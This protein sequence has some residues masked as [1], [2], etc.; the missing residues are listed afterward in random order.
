M[1]EHVLEHLSAYLD[2]ELGAAEQ[3]RFRAH[4]AQ[5]ASCAQRLSELAAVDRSLRELPS[6]APARYFDELPARLRGRL[7][8]AAPP[9]RLRRLPVWTLAVAATLVVGVLAPLTLLNRSAQL[10]APKSA[11]VLDDTRVRSQTAAAAPAATLPLAS[12]RPAATTPPRDEFQRADGK[13]RTI[14]RPK[15]EVLEARAEDRLTAPLPAPTQAAAPPAA[16]PPQAGGVSGGFVPAPRAAEPMAQQSGP[17]VNQQVETDKLQQNRQ[18]AAAPAAVAESVVVT[19]ARDVD[20]VEK[21]DANATPATEERTFAKE[22]ANEK[23]GRAA[24]AAKRPPSA[25][26]YQEL[27]A[28]TA[29]RDADEAQALRDS[30]RRFAADSRDA[31]QA[32]EAR[33]QVIRLGLEAWRL[34]QRIEDRRQ[35]EADAAAYLARDDAHQKDRVRNLLAGKG[36]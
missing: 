8:A 5:C 10:P 21:K 3:E 31:A 28:R 34:G 2:G 6:G 27:Q 35:A 24:L 33:V 23:A 4:L 29:P 26:S 20:K 19:R 36:R 12:P 32:D 22:A 30:W 14:D 17:R 7:S 18:T 13:A 25:A 9:R 11:V 15:R 16:P 1:T